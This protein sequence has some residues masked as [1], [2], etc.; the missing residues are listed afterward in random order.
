LGTAVERKRERMLVVVKPGFE[1]AFEAIFTKWDLTFA[2]I[3]QVT[4][5]VNGQSHQKNSERPKK[6]K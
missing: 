6:T 3:G 5:I 1:K 4:K 2:R